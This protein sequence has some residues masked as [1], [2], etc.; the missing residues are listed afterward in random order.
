MSQIFNVPSSE[1][2]TTAL[3]SSRGF[4]NHQPCGAIRG[5]EK[6]S[7]GTE[8]KA[9]DPVGVFLLFPLQGPGQCI[10]DSHHFLRA[11]NSDPTI[12]VAD[13]GS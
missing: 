4:P 5:C 3:E 13:I 2:V 8:P 6:Q 10:V 7:I 9:V 11:C 12:V 1:A